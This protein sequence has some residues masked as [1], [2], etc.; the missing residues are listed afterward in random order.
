MTAEHGDGESRRLPR[1][2]RISSSRE[3]R[4]LL[5]RGKRSRTAH[6]DVFDSDSPSSHPRVGLIVPKH[7]QTIVRRNKLKRRLR[8]ILRR[9]VLPRMLAG[10]IRADLMVRARR[11]AYDSPFQTLRDELIQWTERRWRRD[12]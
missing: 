3:I 2:R 4:G 1:S 5:Q 6:L 10:S 7:R 11:E 8:E 9:E 12:S